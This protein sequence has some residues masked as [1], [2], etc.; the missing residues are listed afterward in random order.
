MEKLRAVTSNIML[1]IIVTLIILSIILTGASG[2]LINETDKYAAK[3]NGKKISRKQLEEAFQGERSRLQQ[4]LG[5]QFF[6]LASNESY[7]QQLRRQSLEQ[8]INST[9]LNQY[10][11][12]LGLIVS[13]E[14]VK[15]SIRQIPYFQINNKFDN[16]T[17]LNLIT[18]IGYTA[19]YFAQLQRQ[20]VIIK[21]F[22]QAVSNSEFILP[23]EIEDISK[24]IL[25]QRDVRLATFDISKLQT[26]QK[27][28]ESELQAFY[29]QNKNNFITPEEIKVNFIEIDAAAIQDKII[30]SKKDIQAYYDRYKD[31]YKQP[32]RKNFSVI[33]FK[34]KKEAEC[35]LSKLKNGANFSILAKQKST[36]IISR[37]KGGALGWLQTKDIGNE[38]KQ[39]NLT[40]KGQLSGVIKSSVGYL[41]VRLNDIQTEQIKPLNK[42]RSELAKQ[43]R[44]K[45]TL[46]TFYALQQKVSVAAAK[47][48]N[49]LVFAEKITGLKSQQTSWFTRTT[50]PKKLNFKSLTQAM[51]DGSLIGKKGRTGS[52]SDV[53]TVEG[54]KAFVIH[55]DDHKA[56]KTKPFKQVYKEI[57]TLVKRQ[58]AQYFAQAESKKILAALKQD[59]GTAIIKTID[60]RFTKKKTISRSLDDDPL[61]KA[62]FKLAPPKK[63]KPVYGLSQDRQNNVVLIELLNIIPG[64]LPKNEMKDFINQ[65][66]QSAN[67]I[68]FATLMTNLHQQA[69]I[70]IGMTDL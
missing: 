51:F 9:L 20:Q 32:E 47:D 62:I 59:K 65:M 70:K 4:Q 7:M 16:A 33:Q 21:Q 39:A 12:K 19:E 3:V 48:N 31:N 57:I 29:K 10:T 69:T 27:A 34:T 56:E 54:G 8:L 67:G 17:Y 41:L 49:S 38:L 53:I 1:K 30:V 25:Q 5:E 52:N 58:K 15:E 26:Q 23:R 14:Q 42:I 66:W 35:A 36:D 22:L 64:K 60:L 2:Y 50:V 68:T 61:T 28:T 43:V 44:Q 55:I 6:T 11:K 24:L 40:K 46:D 63:N 37:K 45:K 18:S 13:D